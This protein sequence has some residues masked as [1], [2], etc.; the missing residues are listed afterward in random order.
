MFFW[1][2]EIVIFLGKWDVSIMVK[3]L[4][5]RKVIEKNGFLNVGFLNDNN[6]MFISIY[7]FKLKYKLFFIFKNLCY[8]FFLLIV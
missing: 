5:F 1:E 3:I 8:Y 2:K 6:V 4:L 7:L